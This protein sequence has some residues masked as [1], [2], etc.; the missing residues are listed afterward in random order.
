HFLKLAYGRRVAFLFAWARF[1]VI[2]TGAIALL[3]FVLG[4]Y[5]QA[6]RPLGENGAALYAFACVAI[7]TAFNLR[8]AVKGQDEAEYGLTRLEVLG[9]LIVT[10]AGVW[11][12]LQGAP[13]AE[14]FGA[15]GAPPAGFGQ[16]LVFVLLAYGGWSEIATLSAEV[17]DER[18]GMLRALV[19][20]T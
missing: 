4:D 19:W 16:A 18:A 3:G 11:L 5:L 17:K 20:S 7:L 8:G 13:A 10:S 15:M 1:A 14:P 9:V 6:V 2:N 12:F